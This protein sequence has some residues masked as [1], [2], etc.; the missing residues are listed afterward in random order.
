[1]KQSMFLC[2][3]SPSSVLSRSITYQA[4]TTTL[5]VSASIQQTL[6][7]LSTQQQQ[8]QQMV[9]NEIQEQPSQ[10]LI[11]VT[12]HSA[13]HKD[14]RSLTLARLRRDSTHVKSVTLKHDLARNAVNK[15]DLKPATNL[16]VS[17]DLLEGPI[18]SSASQGSGEYFSRV[19]ERTASTGSGGGG[20]GVEEEV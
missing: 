19:G 8:Q 11:S 4:T 18:I 9:E 6:Q 12:L 3:S 20:G 15:S 5:D 14:Y 13:A 7:V 16:E 2:S 17:S 10:D 1:M